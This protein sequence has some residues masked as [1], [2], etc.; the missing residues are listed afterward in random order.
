MGH[1]SH[2][3]AQRTIPKGTK[4]LQHEIRAPWLLVL[5]IIYRI[6]EHS[7]WFHIQY[8][9][10]EDTF[11][12]NTGA[13][14]SHMKMGG[15]QGQKATKQDLPLLESTPVS[16]RS[17]KEPGYSTHRSVHLFLLL[18]AGIVAQQTPFDQLT[19]G[20]G[21][22][23]VFLQIYLF[24]YLSVPAGDPFDLIGR[25]FG[26]VWESLI[27]KYVCFVFKPNSDQTVVL[28]PNMFGV[29]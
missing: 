21:K 15:Q 16:P 20:G 28:F 7:K 17:F 4:G 5:S 27:S 18:L 9:Y 26:S 12:V 1:G 13:W 22:Q 3:R 29:N 25:V 24:R 2:Q 23:Q 8:T 14:L 11:V 6:F 19:C 10:T